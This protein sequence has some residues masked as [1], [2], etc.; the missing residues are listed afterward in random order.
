MKTAR[1]VLFGFALTLLCSCASSG[2]NPE[3][4]METSMGNVKIELFERQAPETVKNFLA[5]VDEKFYDGT[6]FHRVISKFMI[7]GGGFTPDMQEKMTRG[8]IKNESSNGLSNV[9]GTLAMA[10]TA[11]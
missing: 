4:L 1:P 2:P 10:R 6:I 3:V 5:Y 11:D 8:N 9:R 7:Q